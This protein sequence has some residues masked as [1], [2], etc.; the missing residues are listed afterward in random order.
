MTTAFSFYSSFYEAISQLENESD[1][2]A[3]YEAVFAYVF[4]GKKPKLNGV[5]AAIFILIKPNI[6][7]S[8]AR[9]EAGLKGGKSQANGKQKSSKSQASVKQT[10]SKREANAKQTQSKTQSNAKQTSSE[11]EIEI[12]KEIEIERECVRPTLAAIAQYC[13]DKNLDSVDPEKFFAKYSKNDWTENGEPIQNWQALL[14]AWQ[15]KE[16]KGNKFDFVS[17]RKRTPEEWADIET[18]LLQ[19]GR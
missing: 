8:V 18:R 1:R 6:D 4:E 17:Q 19:K 14:C 15:R 11:I 12:E 7:S 13:K 5:P 16:K 2:L 9:R 10:A 3:L